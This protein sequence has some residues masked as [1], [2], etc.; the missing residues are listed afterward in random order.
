MWG[1]W[2]VASITTVIVAVVFFRVGFISGSRTAKKLAEIQ[3]VRPICVCE[4]PI[5][6]HTEA[7][8]CIAE[9]ERREDRAYTNTEWVRCKCMKYT[10]PTPL[11]EFWTPAVAIDE[12][13]R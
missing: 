1:L 4:H 2:L 3:N 9:F 11:P 10:G 12:G 8:G 6:M 7:K 5:S 13:K